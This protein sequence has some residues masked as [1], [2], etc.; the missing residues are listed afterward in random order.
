MQ[1]LPL[2]SFDHWEEVVRNS[3]QA[4]FF[5]TPTWVRVIEKT[6]PRYSNATVG[7]IF[8]GGTRAILPLVA[9]EGHGALFKKVKHKSLALGVYGGILA[10]KRL[11]P[12][13]VGAIVEYLT[14]TDISDLRV[15]EN[16]F[17]QYAL[18]ATFVAK[19]MFT[20]LLALEADF[21]KLIKQISR[22]RIRNMREAERRGVTVRLAASTEDYERY[23]RTYQES[24]KRW[25]DEAGTTYPWELFL[26]LF[27][28]RNPGIKLWLAEKEKKIIAGVLALYCNS[29][30]LLWHGY[31]LP[32]YD[33]CYPSSLLHREMIREGCVQG[34][35]TYDLNPSVE[36]GGVVQFKESLA[37]KRLDFKAYHWK[38]KRWLR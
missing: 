9:E 18:P 21:E 30:I 24:L 16:P 6:Y 2:P 23:Y 31:T 14:S 13:Q 37:A 20:H 5:H 19:P 26:H 1:V 7:F 4:T 25:G 22:G 8:E 11:A 15:V 33:D 32:A 34:Y 17:E 27:E 35:R 10:E 29:T 3:P 12:E 36:R 38:K 28:T